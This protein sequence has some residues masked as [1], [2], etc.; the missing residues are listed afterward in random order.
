MRNQQCDVAKLFPRSRKVL[1]LN[2]A[3]SPPPGGA[4]EIEAK[5]AACAALVDLKQCRLQLVGGPT[6]D[7]EAAA[8]Q[9]TNLRRQ[10]V[11]G[12]QPLDRRSLKIGNFK[13]VTFEPATEELVSSQITCS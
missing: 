2:A 5:M 6:H 9:F 8:Q 4:L 7:D 10:V 1:R 3:A 12:Q 13:A 11:R